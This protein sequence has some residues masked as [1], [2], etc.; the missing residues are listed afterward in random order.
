PIRPSEPPSPPSP[1]VVPPS[2]PPAMPSVGS[3]RP[4]EGSPG[5][6]VPAGTIVGRIGG[7]QPGLLVVILGPDSLLRE[8]GRVATGPDASYRFEK[9]P[10]GRYRVLPMTL[11]GE[12]AAT[13]PA[14]RMVVLTP[15]H[16]VA[17][18]FTVP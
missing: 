15:D 8:A 5:S 11:K 13:T 7:R 6:P 18:D 12:P 9:L 3:Q 1:P 2:A 10:P 4:A 17:C 14:Y 16:G